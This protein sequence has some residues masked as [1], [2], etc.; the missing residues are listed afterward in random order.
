[1][2]IAS[3][4]LISELLKFRKDREWEQFHNARNLSAS[5]V[6]EA[7][8][9]LECFRWAKDAELADIIQRDREDIV[10]E[11][12]DIGILLTYLCVDLH[13]DLEAAMKAKL[14]RNAENYP[15]SLSRGTALKYD[16]LR[17]K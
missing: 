10:T 2:P 3:N 15:I 9:L 16:K 4:E 12:A 13:V 6:I 17:K 14:K 1:M 5:L 11:L 7:A 8:E